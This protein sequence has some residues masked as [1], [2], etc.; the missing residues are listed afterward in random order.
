M[1]QD[2]VSVWR[3]TFDLGGGDIATRPA[4]VFHNEIKKLPNDYNFYCDCQKKNATLKFIKRVCSFL[5][6]L[7]C[8]DFFSARLKIYQSDF[9]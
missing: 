4:F 9:A 5:T 2:G 7:G 3:S 8:V 1:D 6:W